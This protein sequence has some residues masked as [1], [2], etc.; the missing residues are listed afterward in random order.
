LK[1]RVALEPVDQPDVV[2]LI[3]ELDSHLGA[4]YPAESR[5]GLKLEA[6]RAP[7]ILFS[8]ARDEA[9]IAHGCGGVALLDGFAEL[10]RMYV[11]PTAR[12]NGIGALIVTFLERQAL[13][14]G[15]AIMR[16]ETG[17]LQA[18]ALT[19]YE[20]LGYAR[21][22]P[23]APYRLDPNSVFMEK[24]LGVESSDPSIPRTG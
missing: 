17:Y 14:R 12:G 20:R 9:G 2:A 22:E 10:K 13:A 18:A 16:L 7:N 5:H 19:L 6:L 23:F 8:L 1:C 3:G 15:Y 24:R 21:R 11:R 4:L